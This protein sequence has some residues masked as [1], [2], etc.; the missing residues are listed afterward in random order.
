MASR[1][2][3]GG[4]KHIQAIEN[5]V[6]FSKS[7]NNKRPS[8]GEVLVQNQLHKKPRLSESNEPIK[9]SESSMIPTNISND[10]RFNH[11]LISESKLKKGNLE[12]T[13]PALCVSI[14]DYLIEKVEK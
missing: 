3:G 4:R 6:N 13:N 8:T 7:Q 14:L 11:Q 12:K 10:K 5:Y 2:S 9:N 1:R